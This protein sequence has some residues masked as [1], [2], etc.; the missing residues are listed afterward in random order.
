MKGFL[1]KFIPLLLLV[2]LVMCV[3]ACD[4]GKLWGYMT[5]E[6]IGDYEV[7]ED[8]SDLVY[9]RGTVEITQNSLADTIEDI[10]PSVVDISC[11]ATY[12]PTYGFGSA[13]QFTMTGSGVVIS[14]DENY[15]YILG[16]YQTMYFPQTKITQN[17]NYSLYGMVTVV[18][19]F[20]DG[21]QCQATF[22]KFIPTADTGL[23]KVDKSALGSEYEVATPP[24]SW[25]IKDG[26]EIIAI[27]NPLGVLGGTVTT[28][29]MSAERLMELSDELTIEVLQT[30]AEITVN[31]GGILFSTSGKLVGVVY[32]KAVGEGI[33][34]LTFA[35]PVDNMLYAYHSEGFLE[36]VVIGE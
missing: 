4:A 5:G 32:A 34:G 9:N 1:S 18:V 11:S 6:G 28:G 25:S 20:M 23:I 15:I 8:E 10:L 29:I 30:D 24:D 7:A 26:D 17:G 22:V 33:E 36:G 14:E 21:L 13:Q 12:R 16:S 35:I 2:A 27:S 3:S 19:T 31:S